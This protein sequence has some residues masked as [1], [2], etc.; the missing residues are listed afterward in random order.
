MGAAWLGLEFN[1]DFSSPDSSALLEIKFV[2]EHFRK[3]PAVVVLGHPGEGK[4]HSDG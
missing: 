4:R 1:D 3:F 2:R